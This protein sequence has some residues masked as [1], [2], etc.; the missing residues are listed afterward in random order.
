[1][2]NFPNIR[3]LSERRRMKFHP[4][5]VRAIALLT[6]GL[7][8][9]CGCGDG[10][11]D[12]GKK[13]S[14][15]TTETPIP[16]STTDTK[17]NSGQTNP[18]PTSSKGTASVTGKVTFKGTAPK[19]LEIQMKEECQALHA[20]PV[21][22]EEVVV[23]ENGTLKNVIVYVKKGL[24]GK[25]FDAPKDAVVLDQRGCMYNPHAFV[26]QVGQTLTVKSSDPFLHNIKTSPKNN[27]K[28]NIAQDKPMETSQVFKL[29]ETSP[30]VFECN[31]HSWMKAYA[32]VLP[33][34]FH[35]VTKEDGTFELKDLPAGDYTVEAWHEKY[36]TQSKT[37][38][39]VDGEKQ[40][41]EFTFEAK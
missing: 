6:S 29:A 34:P 15:T 13:T 10:T 4:V 25:N 24:E 17:S 26:I 2:V 28:M 5:G 12:G 31:V 37:V 11:S 1:M 21:L 40:T 30:V 3:F 38:K 22:S 32:L 8:G 33:H 16:S 36:G 19:P 39:I 27:P 18:T 23:N 7:I 20:N 41:I 35:A 14:G 9:L